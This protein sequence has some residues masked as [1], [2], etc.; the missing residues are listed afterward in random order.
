MIITSVRLPSSSSHI[1]VIGS[2]ARAGGTPRLFQI[3]VP[4]LDAFFSGTGDMFASLVLVRF[5][6]ACARAGLLGVK[7]W[8]SPDEV[9]ATDLPLAQA[10][11]RVLSSM[12]SVLERTKAEADTVLAQMKPV[13]EREEGSQKRIH[14]RKT[15]ALEVHVVGNIEL[16]REPE[17]RFRAEPVE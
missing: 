16:L 8:V 7:S 3:A 1:S 5:R 9:E 11:E 2:S 15:K 13:L 4:A 10:V 12:Q 17:M 6:E 14:L